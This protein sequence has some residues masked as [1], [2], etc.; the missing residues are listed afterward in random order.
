MSSESTKSNIYRELFQY[1]HFVT[2]ETHDIPVIHPRSKAIRTKQK[3]GHTE[4]SIYVVDRVGGVHKVKLD[5]DVE[6]LEQLMTETESIITRIGDTDRPW[7][8]V[9]IHREDMKLGKVVLIRAD[10]DLDVVYYK[11]S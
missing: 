4:Y 3:D 2:V 5:V 11:D 7:N 6:N 9:I 1:D 10:L 8:I